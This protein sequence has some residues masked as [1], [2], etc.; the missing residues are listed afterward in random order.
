MR[1]IYQGTFK[2]HTGNVVENGT[3]TVCPAGTSTL[4][5]IYTAETG[6]SA[7]TDSAV[8]TDTY[9]HF[10]FY[11]D[12][13]DYALSQ[14]FKIKLSK[15]LLTTKEYDDI[16]IFPSLQ[17]RYIADPSEADQGATG[18]GNTIK[19]LVDSIGGTDKETILLSPGTY[20]LTT[21]E[22]GTSN[23]TLKV[24]PGVT[25]AGVGTLT[26]SGPIEC[27]DYSWI[28]TATIAG[29]YVQ[30]LIGAGAIDLVHK[31]TYV[32]TTGGQRL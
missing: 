18:N 10:Y 24:S 30:T 9:G 14:K 11:V 15:P 19:A 28:G 5:T 12:P 2:D 16:D 21:N 17:Y 13:K 7:D 27:V 26:W 23:I 22:T 32:D 20:T 8:S 3:V 25:F 31:V 1:H 6:G 4:A 29:S